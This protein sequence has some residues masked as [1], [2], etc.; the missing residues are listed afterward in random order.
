MGR[1]GKRSRLDR[2]KFDIH[3]K[4]SIKKIVFVSYF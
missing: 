2:S 1:T 4:T 3:K